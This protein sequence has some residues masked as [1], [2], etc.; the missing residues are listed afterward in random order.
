VRLPWVG[1]AAQIA[2]PVLSLLLLA[3]HFY[4]A[5]MYALVAGSV[6]LA[7]LAF[8]PRAWAGWVLQ[9]T[10]YGAT[11]EWLFTA[12]E[13]AALRAAAGLP[14]ARLLAILG[15]VAALTL[16]SAFIVRGG[17]AFRARLQPD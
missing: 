15:A 6:A 5:E 1:R 13:L 16:T 12:W 4:R 3:A 17:S 9:V 7:T 8:V 11:V 10:L 2:L 14:Y